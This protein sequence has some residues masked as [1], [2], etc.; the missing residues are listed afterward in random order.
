MLI[1]PILGFISSLQWH[2][3]S[4]KPRSA[5]EIQV[6]KKK[7]NTNANDGLAQT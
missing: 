6:L 1:F 3:P 7:K 2:M 5:L 4:E